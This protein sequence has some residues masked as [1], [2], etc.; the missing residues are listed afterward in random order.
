MLESFAVVPYAY[1]IQYS[2]KNDS[3]WKENIQYLLNMVEKCYNCKTRKAKRSFPQ[4]VIILIISFMN[5]KE[6]LISRQLDKVW[7]ELSDSDE[8]WEIVLVRDFGISKKGCQYL[9]S[10]KELY[11][12]MNKS[13]FSLIKG[14]KRRYI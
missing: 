11:Y 4:E 2:L 6:L 10:A 3:Y 1:Y 5:P 13:Y 12:F 7:K 8:V 14:N 9:N